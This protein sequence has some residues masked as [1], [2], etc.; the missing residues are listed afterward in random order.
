MPDTS[1]HLYALSIGSN[2]PL[3]A[4]LT[5]P[6]LLAEAVRQIGALGTVRAL[7]P[8]IETPP[9]GPSRRRFANAALLVDSALPPPAMLAALQGIETGL[10]RRRFQR[11]G[12]RRLDIDIILWSGGRWRSRDLSI[13]HPAFAQRDFVLRPLLAIAGDWKCPRSGHS[14]RHLHALL[15]KAAHHRTARG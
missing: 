3:S 9:I 11:W 15:R 12:A 5:P 13:P 8:T 4:R 10:G 6:R 2:R 1:R 14:I 7:S